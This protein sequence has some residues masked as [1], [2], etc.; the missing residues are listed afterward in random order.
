M[1][2]SITL[3]NKLVYDHIITKKDIIRL[4]V[5]FAESPAFKTTGTIFR[6]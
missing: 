1:Q 6:V 3:N 4:L 5:M 2:I